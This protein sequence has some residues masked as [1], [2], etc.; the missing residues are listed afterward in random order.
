MLGACPS[1]ADEASKNAK[2]EELLTLTHAEGMTGQMFD[3]IRTIELAQLNKTQA[4]PEKRQSMQEMQQRMLKLLHD[5]L[6]W[7]K[8]KPLMV[9]AYADTFTE[10]E[11]DGILN[12][13]KS[14]PGQAMLEKMPLL[15]QRSMALGQQMV[16]DLM[17]QI[18]KMT[19]DMQKQAG[20]QR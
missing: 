13:Y 12:F 5:T 4:P 15:M 14:P 1:F 16:A 11:V 18:Q 20:Q 6:T 17:P 7:D 19:Q 8:M 3:Q 9:K 2:I 10:N